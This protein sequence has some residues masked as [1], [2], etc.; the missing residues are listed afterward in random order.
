MEGFGRMIREE[1]IEIGEKRGR[2]IGEKNGQKKLV[3]TVN[4]LR[5]GESRESILSS[6]IDAGTVD[7]AMQIK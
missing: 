7:L 2:K 4:R 6:G 1:G 5:N 3:E